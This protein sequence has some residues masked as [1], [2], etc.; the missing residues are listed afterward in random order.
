MTVPHFISL[1]GIEAL[2]SITIFPPRVSLRDHR[3]PEIFWELRCN[4]NSTRSFSLRSR[5]LIYLHGF[6]TRLSYQN[7]SAC[8]RCRWSIFLRHSCPAQCVLLWRYRLKNYFCIFCRISA[9]YT[10]LEEFSRRALPFPHQTKLPLFR[11]SLAGKIVRF[12]SSASMGFYCVCSAKAL[13]SAF[14]TPPHMYES[15]WGIKLGDNSGRIFQF[16]ILVTPF[17]CGGLRI[18]IRTETPFLSTRIVNL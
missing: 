6:F 8:P 7:R 5:G 15:L 2:P 1:A 16:S 13:Q 4:R 17:Y 14:K 11:F 3:K 18:K 9:Y 10:Y 12:T